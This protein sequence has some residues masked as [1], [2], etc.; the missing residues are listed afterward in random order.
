MRKTLG[1]GMWM[2]MAAAGPVVVYGHDDHHRYE[3]YYDGE[4][5]DWH[6]WNEHEE[7]AWREYLRERRWEY[8]AWRRCNR[9]ER[10]EYWRWRDG[11]PDGEWGR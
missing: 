4:G 5:R 3:R 6:E 7:R 8:R 10:R 11:H 2:L 9:D 1:L